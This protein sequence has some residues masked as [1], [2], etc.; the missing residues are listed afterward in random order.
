MNFLGTRV[1]VEGLA[2]R[3]T[4]LAV[5]VDLDALHDDL[6]TLLEDVLDG[7]DALLRDLGDVQE[8]VGARDDLDE[9]PDSTIF[10][11]TPL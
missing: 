6:V 3:Q 8:T 9:R 4:D 1:R 2:A 10:F 11:T 7:A 5:T